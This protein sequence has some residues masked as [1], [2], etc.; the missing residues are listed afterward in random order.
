MYMQE[1]KRLNQEK[2]ERAENIISHHYQDQKDQEMAFIQTQYQT[3][4]EA[5]KEQIRLKDLENVQ[6]LAQYHAIEGQLGT[7]DEMAERYQQAQIT[8]GDQYKQIQDLQ[9]SISYLE[10]MLDSAKDQ[11]S[12]TDTVDHLHS[13][14]ASL[15]QD[16][17]TKSEVV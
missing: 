8:I 3:Q 13:L 9:S 14:I 16:L 4:I 7:V 17:A 6:V 15:K 5:L 12:K 1:E 11:A 2:A 10:T